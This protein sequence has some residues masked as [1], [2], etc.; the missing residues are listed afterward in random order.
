[1]PTAYI[2]FQLVHAH[3]PSSSSAHAA[4]QELRVKSSRSFPSAHE[5]YSESLHPAHAIS[6]AHDSATGILARVIQKG[7]VLELR[8]LSLVV[9]PTHAHSGTGAESIR[10]SFPDPLRPVGDGS[11]IAYVEEGR[12]YIVVV[13]EEDV[14][15]RLKFSL[16]SFSGPGD[17]V[18]FKVKGDEDWCEEWE[19]PQDT[20]AACGGVGAIKV[21]DEDTVILGV[22]DGGIVRL[23]RSV[24][25]GRSE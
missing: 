17:R 9:D 12:F 1:M 21:N 15:Y 4:Y 13:S 20:I 6:V 18:A 3:F 14:L 23:T 2:P 24:H 8:N 16:G 7:Y 25:W 19:I 11:I 22:G 5:A 10:I